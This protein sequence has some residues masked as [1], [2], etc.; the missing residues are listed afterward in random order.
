MVCLAPKSYYRLLNSVYWI[1]SWSY[2]LII[3][4]LCYRCWTKSG[5]SAVVG[6]LVGR[7]GD[8][9]SSVSRFIPRNTAICPGYCLPVLIAHCSTPISPLILHCT[10]LHAPSL[11]A[12][13]V[14]YCTTRYRCKW[15][16]F[17]V[18]CN[19]HLISGKKNIILCSVD[20]TWDAMHRL[21]SQM[22]SK[23]KMQSK[24]GWAVAW[25]AVY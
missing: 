10:V 8:Q 15:A 13:N 7:W 4:P 3:W 25:F 21:F 19:C 17:E 5:H 23:K 16:E 11:A 24:T 18:Y 1:L 22:Q 9:T 2:K 12:G 14:L 6:H 20:S